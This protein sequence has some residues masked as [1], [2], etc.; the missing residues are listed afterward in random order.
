MI[1][2]AT[3]FLTN[4]YGTKLQAF[5]LQSFL[6]LNNFQCEIIDYRFGKKQFNP[7]KILLSNRKQYKMIQRSRK[8]MLENNPKMKQGYAVRNKQFKEFSDK[9]YH[10]SKPCYTLSDVHALAKQ[11]KTVICGSDQIWLPSHIIE[12]YYTLL[13]LPPNVKKIAYAPSFGIS[14]IPYFFRSDYKKMLMHFDTLTVRENEGATIVKELAGVNAEVVV[15]PTLLLSA[16]NWVNML[17]IAQPTLNEKYVMGYFIGNSES[18]RQVARAYA[19]QIGAKL[20]ILPHIGEFVDA[21]EKYADFTP[22]DIGPAEF[23]NLIKNADAVFTDSFHGTVFSLIFH[24]EVYCFE[25]FKNSNKNST[26]SRMHSLLK[27]VGIENRLITSDKSI[28][29]IDKIDY[30]SVQRKIDLMIKKSTE[31]L[32]EALNNY[33]YF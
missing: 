31:L 12:K 28:I 4:N 14:R 1:G 19:D 2:L 10:F 32:K 29:N 23:V 27:N 11:Y 17:G 20:V 18:H 6:I 15:D 26:N 7:K 30:D 8:A 21:D 33:E 3:P 5:A 24:K 25:R 22:Y 16:D 13:Y 9:Y